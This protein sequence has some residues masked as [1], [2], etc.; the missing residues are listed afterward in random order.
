ME[1]APSVAKEGSAFGRMLNVLPSPGEVFQEIKE[2]P[3][4]HANWLAPA[5]VWALIGAVVVW[6]L[7]SMPAIQYEMK[8]QQEKAMQRQ[9][10]EGKLKQEQVDQILSNM[11]PWV[12]T[13]MKVMAVVATFVYA[14]GLPFFWGFVIWMLC[15]NIYKAEIE[16][17][18]GVE[19]AGL[20]SIIYVL[21]SVVGGLLS[22]AMGQMTFVSPAFFLPEMDMS[23]RTHMVLAA[24]N[25]FYLWYAVVLAVSV[26]VLANV[27]LRR[28]LM[29][30][31][32][33]WLLIRA[34]ALSN[35][36]TMNFVL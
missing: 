31:L 19:A 18:K 27:P 5:T 17:M 32:V 22:M 26:S 1:P 33:V 29:W 36:Y 35:P 34:L 20:A 3:V 28:P 7:F 16:Y 9:V 10:T 25:P 23:N 30:C 11:P 4:N 24:L 8:K 2:K 12:M 6:I 21:A 14:F 13:A 15:V